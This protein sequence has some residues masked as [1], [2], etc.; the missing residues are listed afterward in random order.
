MKKT[1]KALSTSVLLAL[2][3]HGLLTPSLRTKGTGSKSNAILFVATDL[4]I[5][6]FQEN[7]SFLRVSYTAKGRVEIGLAGKVSTRIKEKRALYE[8]QDPHA[9]DCAATACG[10]S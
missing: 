7:T 9:D 2:V 5:F 3:A 1:P 8:R 4:A 10:H 6:P